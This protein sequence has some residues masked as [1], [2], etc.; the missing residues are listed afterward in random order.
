MCSV[1]KSPVRVVRLAGLLACLFG[2]P[3]LAQDWSVANGGD[4]GRDGFTPV[5]GPSTPTVRWEYPAFNG[6]PTL[7]GWSAPVLTEGNLGVTVRTDNFT[8]PTWGSFLLFFDV[9]SGD[10]VN[11]AYLPGDTTQTLHLSGMNGGRVYATRSQTGTPAPLVCISAATGAV[12]WSSVASVD[13]GFR[14]GCTFAADGDPIVGDSLAI[15]RINSVDGKTVWQAERS[16]P[17]SSSHEVVVD[18]ARGLVYAWAGQASSNVSLVAYDLNTGATRFSV[19]PGFS[20]PSPSDPAPYAAQVGNLCVSPDGTIYATRSSGFGNYRGEL[21]AYTVQTLGPGGRLGFRELWRQTTGFWPEGSVGVGPAG[22]VYAV[23]VETRNNGN[24][25]WR[26]RLVRLDPA[27]GDH[28][29]KGAIFASEWPSIKIVADGAG[30]VFAVHSAVDRAALIS[31]NPDCTTR[32]S[33]P[34]YNLY[35]AGPCIASDGSILISGD[36]DRLTA[37]HD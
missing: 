7:S 30:T 17:W 8:F 12:Q 20:T 35:G 21:I 25:L 1:P 11:F 9:T 19:T 14:E 36:F 22:E 23:D 34:W 10:I 16:A 6:P 5:I 32:W 27:T 18:E 15:T 33:R 29:A 3:A 28:L 31:F 4:A 13:E 2:A 24:S 26:W 37:Y